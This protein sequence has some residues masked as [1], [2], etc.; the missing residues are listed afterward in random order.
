MGTPDLYP[1]GLE[2]SAGISSGGS[3]VELSPYPV[4]LASTLGNEC[5]NRIEVLATPL[6]S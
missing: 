2:L 5:Q 6:V 4:G 3:V 1:V